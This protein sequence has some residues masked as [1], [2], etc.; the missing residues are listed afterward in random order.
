MLIFIFVWQIAYAIG[1]VVDD[2]VFFYHAYTQTEGYKDISMIN[3][4]ER[5]KWNEEDS[6]QVNNI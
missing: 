3:I 2:Y 1:S 4:C 5:K 6:E